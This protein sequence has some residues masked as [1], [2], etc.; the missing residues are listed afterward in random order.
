MLQN[1]SRFPVMGLKFNNG[2]FIIKNTIR[3]ASNFLK[4]D[5][6]YEIDNIKLERVDNK[7]LIDQ[8]W[9]TIPFKYNSLI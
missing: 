6:N 3:L 7:L 1:L 2:P 8:P 9:T 4:T 5:K